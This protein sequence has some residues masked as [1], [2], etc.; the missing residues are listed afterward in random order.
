MYF[1]DKISVPEE[2]LKATESE[3]QAMLRFVKSIIDQY[4][5]NP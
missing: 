3:K 1:Q 4:Q 5:C 2:W